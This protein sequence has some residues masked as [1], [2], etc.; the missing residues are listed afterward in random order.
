MSLTIYYTKVTFMLN[1]IYKKVNKETKF[2]T[3]S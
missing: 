1:Y 3:F 2:F